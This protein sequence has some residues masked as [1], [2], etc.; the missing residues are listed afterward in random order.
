REA[1]QDVDAELSAILDGVSTHHV[2]PATDRLVA[3]ANRSANERD[4]R[5]L[6]RVAN[7]IVEKAMDDM[8]RSELYAQLC[9][10]ISERID[11]G[12]RASGVKA[13]NGKRC[14]G[15]Q[16]FRKFLLN[17]CQDEF[18]RGVDEDNTSF[19]EIATRR[20]RYLGLVKFLGELFKVKL[21]TERI[22]QQTIQTFL[23]NIE[24]PRDFH[25]DGLHTILTT[26]GH[27][28][29]TEE[30]REHLDVY[31]QHIKELSESNA[32]S[33]RLRLMLQ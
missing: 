24:S 28:L 3:Y 27:L 12:I 16:L 22:I 15:G 11:P 20:Q 19:A 32:V 10:G 2:T 33:P 7:V 1:P 6:I 13:A 4:G 14:A 30:G 25:I 5:S 17:R 21:L 29:D 18:E 9:H 26:V 23:G 31:F 8:G